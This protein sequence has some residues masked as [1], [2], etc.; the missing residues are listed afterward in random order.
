MPRPSK[1]AQKRHLER[2]AEAIEKIVYKGLLKLDDL[3]TQIDL[4]SK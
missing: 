4:L 1:E 3:Q 2:E